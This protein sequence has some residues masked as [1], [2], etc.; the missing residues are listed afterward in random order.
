MRRLSSWLE[1][2]TR[3]LPSTISTGVEFAPLRCMNCRAWFIR[4]L[5]AKLDIVLANCLGST[6]NR[7]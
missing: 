2:V 7:A 5:T 6:P 4:A 3:Y 1:P